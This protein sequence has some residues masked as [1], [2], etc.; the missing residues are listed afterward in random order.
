[1]GFIVIFPYTPIS[2]FDFIPF[3]YCPLASLPFFLPLPFF[4]VIHFLF[5]GYLG[6]GEGLFICLLCFVSIC[7]RKLVLIFLHL[8]NF[9]YHDDLY[10]HPFLLQMTFILFYDRAKLHSIPGSWANWPLDLKFTISS[11]DSQVFYKR[12]TTHCSPGSPAG[13]ADLETSQHW[14]ACELLL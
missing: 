8:A 1:M 9:V 2:H 7:E 10:F 14:Q 5:S 3:P 12:G 13:L 6:F 4:L 11:S